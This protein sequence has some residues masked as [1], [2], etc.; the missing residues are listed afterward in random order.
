MYGRTMIASSGSQ[1][2]SA[3]FTIEPSTLP[4]RTGQSLFA[5]SRPS[6][7]HGTDGPPAA[8]LPEGRHRGSSGRGGF[9]PCEAVVKE[10]HA[11]LWRAA[12]AAMPPP[13][14][15]LSRVPF[16]QGCPLIGAS[17]FPANQRSGTDRSRRQ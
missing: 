9:H 7:A 4:H 16:E 14:F 1:F 15:G 2:I 3:S 12:A 5:A 13:S 11:A 10:R 8:C 6:R 17:P